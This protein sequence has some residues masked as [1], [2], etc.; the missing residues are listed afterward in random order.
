MT[1]KQASILIYSAY[2][3]EYKKKGYMLYCPKKITNYQWAIGKFEPNGKG[4]VLW[5]I[6][7]FD[8]IT[9]IEYCI[10][11]FKKRFN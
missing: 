5:N 8:D 2:N 11:E 10:E 4:K 3:K 1:D 6:A 7:Y 9:N